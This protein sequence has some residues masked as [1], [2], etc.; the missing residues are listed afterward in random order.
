MKPGVPEL[1]DVVQRKRMERL[2]LP[3]PAEVE[4]DV[5]GE[6]ALHEPDPNAEPD[7]R[8]ADGAPREARLAGQPYV[9]QPATQQRPDE[10]DSAR[11]EH[12]GE[13]HV[14]RRAEGERQR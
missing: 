14:E 2:E 12:E 5:A 6:G 4:E 3:D 10:G 9:L 13:R 11:G 1:P 8:Q 7:T